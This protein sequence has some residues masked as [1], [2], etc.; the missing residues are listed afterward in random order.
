MSIAALDSAIQLFARVFPIV[1]IRCKLQILQHFSEQLKAVK[2]NSRLQAL[3]LNILTAICM[4]YKNIG[5]RR[6]CVRMDDEQ[7]QQESVNLIV[8][9]LAGESILLK[10]LAV[11][12]L[13]RLA[14]AIGTPQVA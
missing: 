4:A 13:G 12:A 7:M 8:P 6:N 3:Q 10:C 1:S 14:L 2:I 5:E 9:F 11:E